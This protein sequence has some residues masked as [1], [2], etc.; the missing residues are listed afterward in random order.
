M[1][2][3]TPTTIEDAIET[4]ALG[5]LSSASENGRQVQRIPI[6]D[7]IAADRHLANKR[8]SSQPHFGLRMTKAIPPGGG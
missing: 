3:S 2:E 7:L 6:Q 8:A 5:M 1:T 4:M